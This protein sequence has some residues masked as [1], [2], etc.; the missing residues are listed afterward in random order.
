MDKIRKRLE[1][2]KNS[3]FVVDLKLPQ[4]GENVTQQASALVGHEHSK[5]NCIYR[6]MVSSR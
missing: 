1:P 3:F 4:A 6:S 5:K 2:I